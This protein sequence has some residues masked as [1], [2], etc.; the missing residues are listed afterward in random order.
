[1]IIIVVILALGNLAFAIYS[2]YALKQLKK[3]RES[4]Q[5]GAGLGNLEEVLSAISS[6]IKRLDRE[7]KELAMELANTKSKLRETTQKTGVHK[8]NAY[9][10]DGGNLSFSLAM[11]NDRDSGI[12]LTSLH[13]RNQ[14]RIY[15]KTIEQGQSQQ[16]L[17]AEELTAIELSKKS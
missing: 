3:L 17:T 8:F 15:A 2:Y 5:E 4:F 13:T 7:T 1:M 9:E 14:T 10:D 12:T 6:Q 16:N 11:L